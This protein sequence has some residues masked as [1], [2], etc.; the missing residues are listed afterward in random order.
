[1]GTLWNLITQHWLSIALIIGALLAI[2][3]VYKHKDQLLSDS[4]DS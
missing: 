1:M 4:N 2:W 3:F